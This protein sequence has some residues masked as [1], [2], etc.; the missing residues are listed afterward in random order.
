ML[1]Q[2]PQKT[3]NI[4]LDAGMG[5]ERVNNNN[6]IHRYLKKM[7][8]NKLDAVFI[9][10]QH[11]DHYNNL[12]FLKR[13]LP[14][15]QVVSNQKQIQKYHINELT[16]N[17]WAY[18]YYQEMEKENNRSL[19]L[20]TEISRYKLLFTFDLE[21]KGEKKL[22]EQQKLKKIDILQV[23]HHG[24]GTSSGFMFLY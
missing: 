11:Y 18:D 3:T 7:G 2:G 16:F 17:N 12:T 10:H 21:R 19:V 8:V 14:I 20:Y 22:I 15:G 24:S 23:G 13:Q 6:K 9:S 5:K 1:L 4:L